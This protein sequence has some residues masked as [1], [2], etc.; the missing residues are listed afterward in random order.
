MEGRAHSTYE[1]LARPAPLPPPAAIRERH[2]LA[3]EDLRVERVPAT[4]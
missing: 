3:L 2:R 4:P 1:L